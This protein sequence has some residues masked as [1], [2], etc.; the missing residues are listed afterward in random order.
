MAPFPSPTG[1][2]DVTVA[3]GTLG[4]ALLTSSRKTNSNDARKK[5]LSR[6]DES[7][8]ELLATQCKHPPPFVPAPRLLA[9]AFRAQDANVHALDK[10]AAAA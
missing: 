1:L 7:H 5:Q 6:G 10:D 3:A 4:V 2:A 8:A 9:E